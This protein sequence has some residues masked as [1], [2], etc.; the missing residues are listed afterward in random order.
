MS[1]LLAWIPHIGNSAATLIKPFLI[2]PFDFSV[3]RFKLTGIDSRVDTADNVKQWE[4]FGTML[5]AS[6]SLF[7]LIST[8]KEPLGTPS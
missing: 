8:V 1:L 2:Q 7:L 4:L 5:K 3:D 6:T